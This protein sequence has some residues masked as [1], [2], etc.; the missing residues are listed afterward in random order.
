MDKLIMTFTGGRES[1]LT[2]HRLHKDYDI[3]L[4]LYDYG[5]LAYAKEYEAL[6]YYT[7]KY[8]VKQSYTYKIPMVLPTSLVEGNI[9]KDFVPFRNH[10]FI[11]HLLHLAE[12]FGISIV[13]F[14]I[15]KGVSSLDTSVAFSRQIKASLNQINSKIRIITPL[16]NIQ[17]KSLHR[18]LITEKVDIKKL[19]FC[20]TK[21]EKH[22]GN[23]YK[24]L[25]LQ[26]LYKKGNKKDTTWCNELNIELCNN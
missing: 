14:G 22:C 19:W 1:L 24:C 16:R 11:Y 8:N 13:A 6:Q 15:T 5:Q 17:E 23:C 9:E 7:K 2:L 3:T 4:V 20:N 10:V 25:N 26:K 12:S 18:V 21:E